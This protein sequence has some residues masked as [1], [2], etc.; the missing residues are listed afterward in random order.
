MLESVCDGENSVTSWNVKNPEC[1]S[2][3]VTEQSTI[4]VYC[5]SVQ[6]TCKCHL[7]FFRLETFPSTADTTHMMS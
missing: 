1:E 5:D 6:A 4:D 3:I 7:R 2:T